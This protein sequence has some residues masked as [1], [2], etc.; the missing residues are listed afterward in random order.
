MVSLSDTA[1]PSR[2]SPTSTTSRAATTAITFL[3]SSTSCTCSRAI[4]S[5]FAS[6]SA[7]HLDRV[8]R[9]RSDGRSL[10]CQWSGAGPF[11]GTLRPPVRLRTL[12]RLLLCQAQLGSGALLASE[13][14]RD[15][16]RRQAGRVYG[17]STPTLAFARAKCFLSDASLRRAQ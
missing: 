14:I 16:C 8:A 9:Q 11:R 13:K 3:S 1:L 6:F 7:L 15:V 5:R 4:P 12:G 10:V 2:T 17:H